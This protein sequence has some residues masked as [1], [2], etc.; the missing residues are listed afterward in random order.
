MIKIIV[1]FFLAA[2]AVVFCGCDPLTVHKVSSTVF[3]GFPT[4]PPPEQYCKDYH[5]LATL[6]ELAAER[7]Q[8]REVVMES[9]HPPYE[10]KRCNDCHDKNTESGFVVPA[11]DLCAHCHKGFP[12]GRFL[13]GPAA[14]GGCLKCHLPHT[15][16]NPSL[17]V[18]PKGDVCGICHTE[19]RATQQLHNTMKTRGLVCTDCHDPHGGNDHFFLR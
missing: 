7:K 9:K 4:M 10:E 15:S 2:S 17:L 14:V 16:Q 12:T 3:D 8:Q 6:D 19:A 5:E 11:A 13:H 18:K 1:I